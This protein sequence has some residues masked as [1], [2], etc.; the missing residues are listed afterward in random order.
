ML[1]FLFGVGITLFVLKRARGGR[2]F[3]RSA[4]S[5]R[6]RRRE[7]VLNRLSSRLDTT[8]SQDREL[9]DIVDDLMDVMTEER[10][11]FF[12][13]REALGQALGGEEFDG[14]ALDDLRA[15]QDEALGR[16]HDALGKAL[17]SAHG[18]LDAEQREILA[19]WINRG[20][21]H[22][23]HRRGRHLHAA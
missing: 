13:S 10:D 20:R 18:T 8:A 23:C 12:G 14:A 3:G 15:R 21:G 11:A 9:E 17:K 4:R 22:H 6:R 16:M 7:W 5:R 19:R 1:G 2:G